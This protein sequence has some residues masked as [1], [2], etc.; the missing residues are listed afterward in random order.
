MRLSAIKSRTKATFEMGVIYRLAE[1]TNDPV[2]QGALADDLVRV[3]GHE[4]RW[5]RVTRIHKVSVELD[6]GH[7]RHLNVAHHARGG[8]EEGRR[9]EIGCRREHL[10]SVAQRRHELAHGFAEE[11]IILDDRDQY[12]FRHR[13]LSWLGPH[14]T[15]AAHPSRLCLSL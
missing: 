3:C 1:V 12:T 2:L 4:D 10:H 8:S 11:L 13:S 7:S 15:G 6:S 14:H 5:N 9:E